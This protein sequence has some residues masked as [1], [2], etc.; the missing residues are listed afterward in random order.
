MFP[1]R[2]A[3][4]VGWADGNGEMIRVGDRLVHQQIKVTFPGAGGQ[5]RLEAVIDSQTG[6]PRVTDL[7]VTSVEDGREVRSTDLRSIEVES[8]LEAIVPLFTLEGEWGE[9]GSFSGVESIADSQSDEFRRSRSALREV[10]R[11]SRRKVTPELLAQ[12]AEVY[13]ANPDRPAEA[14]EMAFAT[15][16]R[17]AFRYI[18]MAREQ[19]ILEPREGS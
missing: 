2:V 5:P 16:T 15:S 11:A 13:R 14:V 3:L 19:G 9:D 18:S 8:L 10:R 1:K 12:V 4:N 17:T 6:V 7:T